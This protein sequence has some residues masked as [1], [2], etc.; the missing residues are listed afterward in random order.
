MRSYNPQ[1]DSIKKEGT[2]GA[3]VLLIHGFTGTPDSMRPLANTLH[4]AG[5]SVS[6]PLLAGHGLTPEKCAV[7]HWQDWFETANQAYQELQTRF[8]KV[9]VAGLSLG[10]LLTLK[11]AMEYP[12]SIAGIA[13][14]AT[15][16]HFEP[17]VRLLLPIVH[18]SPIGQIWRYQKKMEIDIK[19]P[20]AKKSFWNYDRMPISCIQSILNLQQT[21]LPLLHRVTQ[22]ILLIHSRHDSTAPYDSMSTVT[23]HVSSQI[24]E[25]VTLENSYH[26]ITIDYEKEIVANKVC[27]FFRRFL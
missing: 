16:L 15:P 27:D 14:L 20:I 12:K 13:C 17:W 10:S 3:G 25:T 19:D 2:N 21:L 6:V 11:L 23:A 7:T 8:D 22:P 24:T 9:F 5:F 4:Q 1:L 26:V 18:Y